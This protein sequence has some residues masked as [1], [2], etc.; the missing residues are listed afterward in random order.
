MHNSERYV[1]AIVKNLL[2]FLQKLGL[3]RP[4][5]RPLDLN[6]LFVALELAAMGYVL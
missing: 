4:S 2:F 3:C 5:V 1:N 6:Y